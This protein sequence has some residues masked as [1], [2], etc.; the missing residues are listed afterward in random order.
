MQG[1]MLKIQRQ[2]KICRKVFTVE[3]SEEAYEMWMNGVNIQDAAPEM[4]ADDR[5][6]L[7]SGFCGKC[8][9][10]LFEGEE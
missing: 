10:S 5:E 6:L 2:C 4:S 7:I 8:Y 3:I 1:V 9:D